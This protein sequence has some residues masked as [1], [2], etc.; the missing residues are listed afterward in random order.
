MNI[1][2]LGKSQKEGDYSEDQDVDW[3]IILRRILQR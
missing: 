2:Y 3:W 1:S